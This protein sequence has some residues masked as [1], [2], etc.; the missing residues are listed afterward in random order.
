MYVKQAVTL[1]REFSVKQHL[2]ITSS[3]WEYEPFWGVLCEQ[4]FFSLQ[5][6]S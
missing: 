5:N 6:A 2:N 4:K 1:S 3:A